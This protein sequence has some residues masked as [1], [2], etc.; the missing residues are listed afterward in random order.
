[1]A[2]ESCNFKTSE[3][4]M[5]A[6][7]RTKGLIDKYLNIT[8]HPEFQKQNRKW[9]NAARIKFGEEVIKENEKLF[10][11]ETRGH[12]LVAIPNKEVFKKIDNEKGIYYS[13]KAFHGSPYKVETFSTNNTNTGEGSA[14]FGW[15]LYFTDKED[16]AKYYAKKL[17]FLKGDEYVYEVSLHSGKDPSEYNYIRWD[18]KLSQEQISKL[19]KSFKE[20]N[21]EIT[22]VYDRLGKLFGQQ[23][24]VTKYTGEWFYGIL[25]NHFKNQK[26]ASE[27]L[28]RLGID[29]I[30]YPTDS[31][32]NKKP[33]FSKE[34]FNYVV[35]D[36]TAVTIKKVTKN[37]K[38]IEIKS[39]EELSLELEDKLKLFLNNLGVRV[40]ALESLKAK[41]GVDALG[42]ADLINKVIYV[43]ENRKLD[44]LPEEVS[45]FFIEALGTDNPLVK[46]LMKDVIDTPI[47]KEVVEQYSEV[48]NNNTE[49][50]Q[51][52][53]IGKLLGEVIVNKYT[54]SRG[55]PGI[56]E[57]IKLLIN[58]VL[59]LFKK[60]RP[61]DITSTIE[62]I[63]GKMAD[64]IL[65]A[66][67]VGLDLANITESSP[68][69]QIYKELKTVSEMVEAKKKNLTARYRKYNS[70]QSSKESKSYAAEINAFVA[71]LHK[72]DSEEAY[73]K[74]LT[75]IT[76]ELS[77]IEDKVASGKYG[78]KGI[79]KAIELLEGYQGISEVEMT[80]PELKKN[81]TT[82]EGQI[83]NLLA[84]VRDIGWTKLGEVL[85]KES[86][87]PIEEILAMTMDIS[88]MNK[89]MGSMAEARDPLLAL[90]DKIYKKSVVSKTN[91]ILIDF[92]IQHSTLL[93][94]VSPSDLE[95]I[96]QKDP[97]G[98]QTGYLTHKYSKAYFNELFDT[99]NK[100]K[101]LED[102]E[103]KKQLWRDFYKK[104]NKVVSY[105]PET[106]Y[107]ITEPKDSYID[108]NWLRIQSN[109][110]L[111]EYYD[112]YNSSLRDSRIA[113]DDVVNN[114]FPVKLPG[115]KE[116]LLRQLTKD[117]TLTTLMSGM[118]DKIRDAFIYET[119]NKDFIVEDE[120]GKEVKFV[121]KIGTNFPKDS[122]GNVDLSQMSFD[123]AS[124]LTSFKYFSEV[125]NAKM[126][127]KPELDLLKSLLANKDYIVK[128]NTDTNILIKGTATNAYK[129]FEDWY[130]M[131][132]IGE[133]QKEQEIPYFEIFDTKISKQ[134]V[135]R[136]V[137]NYV[138]IKALAFNLFSGVSNILFGGAQQMIEAS[139][140]EYYG[141]KDYAKAT[142]QY[143]GLIKNSAISSLLDF[144]N[145]RRPS[146]LIEALIKQYAPIQD[147]TE[148]SKGNQSLAGKALEKL[149]IFNKAGE[150]MLQV[151][152]FLAMMNSK[153]VRNAKGDLI[154][155]I[156]AYTFEN[157]KAVLKDDVEFTKD[158]EYN[159]RNTIIGVNQ[160]LHGRYTAEDASALQQYAL[161]HLVLQFRKW[162][163]PGYEARFRK[164][165]PDERL[166]KQ[167]KGRYLS[168]GTFAKSLYEYK[169]N[170]AKSWNTLNDVDKANMRRNITGLVYTVGTV[171]MY[172]L[173]K[174]IGEDDDELKDNRAFNFWLYQADRWNSELAFYANPIETLNI[175]RSPAASISTVENVIKLTAS[176]AKYP[177]QDD[178]ERIVR[179]K[180]YTKVE[181][182]LYKAVPVANQIM[183]FKNLE[184]PVNFIRIW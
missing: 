13:I 154:P 158:E 123:L 76:K 48:Y 128:S 19:E 111:K 33:I 4:S 42:A 77:L 62:E 84:Q 145:K 157:G 60:A 127:I 166:G 90:T 150:H 1:M 131:V 165:Y 142:A 117:P 172:N 24:P 25:A 136:T 126:E 88:A 55:K 182:E 100:S 118:S 81:A 164:E 175:L 59:S 137:A 36:E 134:K 9:S 51:K 132:F 113:Y 170:I 2:K 147:Q 110:A 143:A 184:D 75:N 32:F 66:D 34:G 56:L 45:H 91:D 171:I 69:F 94:K 135:A 40:E 37:G 68:M 87:R 58:R 10:Y 181:R 99:I 18:K 106:G 140:G 16:I 162:M 112:F 104:T 73:A 64:Q 152:L 82:L 174:S 8:N 153:K 173:L 74:L 183:R 39:N 26:E 57:T 54:A 6:W 17:S 169:F 71:A 148:F 35:F 27:F 168:Y 125:Y 155:L 70:R 22:E 72:L 41:F 130:N 93:S 109:P 149:F 103:V 96:I 116:G 14:A 31:F 121:K 38:V 50:L 156:E 15:G 28:L 44:T 176:M 53:A 12:N 108:K 102:P 120:S 46:K 92:D 101:E 95:L 63:Y 49:L 124:I 3:A 89:T 61:T 129:R 98:K 78:V 180:D 151:R 83:T 65:S 85:S 97:N 20:N 105:D 107:P 144:Q 23:A 178:E 30:Q 160:R 115:F 159:Y 138:S 114:D 86:T 29:G 122:E 161:G 119:K 11:E 167:V 52:E 79:G 133:T 5:K 21:I 146:N 67:V 80:N 7:M 139:A 141:F 47:Y 43:A 163:Y 179:G 177:F